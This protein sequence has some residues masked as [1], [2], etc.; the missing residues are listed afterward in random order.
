M[1]PHLPER[2]RIQVN[3][4]NGILCDF[5][6]NFNEI[7]R[8]LNSSRTRVG[9]TLESW[10]SKLRGMPTY[11]EYIERK[12]RMKPLIE[13]KSAIQI[14]AELTETVEAKNLNRIV[15]ELRKIG[16]LNPE[17]HRETVRDLVNDA[18]QIFKQGLDK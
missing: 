15:L 9:D 16:I 11:T 7:A 6:N 5:S 13:K 2:F 1:K 18:S 3:P 4:N 10:Q 12:C 8:W 17:E 14:V